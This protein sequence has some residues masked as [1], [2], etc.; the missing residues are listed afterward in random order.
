MCSCGCIFPEDFIFLSYWRHFSYVFLFFFRSSC[1]WP[2]LTF[3]VPREPILSLSTSTADVLQHVH[4]HKSLRKE[5]FYG[6]AVYF[7]RVFVLSIPTQI[8]DEICGHNRIWMNSWK[9]EKCEKTSCLDRLQT[10]T[11]RLWHSGASKLTSAQNISDSR[12]WPPGPGSFHGEIGENF[13]DF[14]WNTVGPW[15]RLIP[16]I[17]RWI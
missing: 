2:W 3:N 14:S 12:D 6:Y 1:A 13:L 4:V 16:A 5:L 11:C 9:W 7:L 17:S 10:Y 15:S 8:R